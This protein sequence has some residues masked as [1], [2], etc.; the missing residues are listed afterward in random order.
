M[1]VLSEPLKKKYSPTLFCNL[2]RKNLKILPL[3]KIKSEYLQHLLRVAVELFYVVRESWVDLALAILRTEIAK[4]IRWYLSV[5]SNLHI[6][7][8]NSMV[9]VLGY[10]SKLGDKKPSF[11]YIPISKDTWYVVT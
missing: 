3:N 2:K 8:K 11:E 5:R 1:F 9:R 6:L 7:S 4:T 10:T